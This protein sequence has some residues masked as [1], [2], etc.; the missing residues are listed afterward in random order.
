MLCGKRDSIV[1]TDD[2]DLKT[3][4]KEALC[5]VKSF[6]VVQIDSDDSHSKQMSL[7]LLHCYIKQIK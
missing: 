6:K 1:I 3:S 4:F 5:V 2:N 7:S